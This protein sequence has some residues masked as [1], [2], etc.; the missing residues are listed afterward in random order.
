MSTTRDISI[1]HVTPPG[2]I[3]VPNDLLEALHAHPGDVLALTVEDDGALRLHPRRLR[4]RD[5]AGMLAG[6]TNIT[7]T[8]AEMDDAV[9]EAFRK[10][11]L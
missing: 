4:A 11:E 9:A 1:A 3:A 8:L 6:R 10:G 7:S 2:Q 5:V